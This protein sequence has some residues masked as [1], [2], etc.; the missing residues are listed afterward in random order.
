MKFA[1]GKISPKGKFRSSPSPKIFTSNRQPKPLTNR[2]INAWWKEEL[3]NPNKDRSTSSV[4]HTGEGGQRT[5]SCVSSFIGKS[6]NIP[7][8]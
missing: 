1:L 6:P 5:Q 4:A 7:M 8:S 2:G 3:R